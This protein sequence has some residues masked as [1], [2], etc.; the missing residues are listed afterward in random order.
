[1]QY[2]C[3]LFASLRM[4]S[5]NKNNNIVPFVLH[6]VV[7][8]V[9]MCYIFNAQESPSKGEIENIANLLY[10]G[11]YCFE[12]ITERDL[13]SVICGIVGEVYFGDGNE[14]NCC[15][16]NEVCKVLFESQFGFI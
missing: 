3:S 4:C 8:K 9:F 7:H 6:S 13:D 5:Y 16:I 2:M 11:F 10:N 1:M 12:A 15:D 14:K